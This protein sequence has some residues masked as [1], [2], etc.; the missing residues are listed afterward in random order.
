MLSVNLDEKKLNSGNLTDVFKIALPLILVASSNSIKLFSDRSMLSHYS[1]AQMEAA[2][3]SGIT[4]FTML[5]FFI[6]VVSYCN[7]FVS[8]FYG[9]KK[10]SEIGK[11]IWQGIFIS[12]FAGIILGTGYFWSDYLFSFLGRD[13][14]MHRNQVAYVKVLYISSFFPLCMATLTNFWGG[15]GKTWLVLLIE[16]T[17][18]ILNVILN[19]CL[20]FG[21]FGFPECGLLGAAYAT[22]ASTVVGVVVAFIIFLSKSNREQFNTLP[23]KFFDFQLA[24]KIFIYGSQNGIR[25]VLDVGAFNV[26]VILL[27]FYGPLVGEAS[28]IVFTVN[29]LS[30]IP[31]FGI[32]NSVSI[33]VGHGIGSKD[34]EMSKR[35]VGSG[36]KILLIYMSIV[37]S[38][39]TLCNDIPLSLF[40][41]DSK[42]LYDMTKLF[43]YFVACELFFN[44]FSILYSSAISGAG[45]TAFPM[46]ITLYVSWGVFVLPLL[47][48]Y[49]SGVSYMIA[50]GIFAFHVFPKAVILYLRYRDGVWQKMSVI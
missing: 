28:T 13:A 33:L 44:G 7:V 39:L 38:L 22:A 27:S 36:L 5:I 6:A 16:G 17:T 2:F 10:Y 48:I 19:Y 3:T 40:S 21:R 45:D 1:N 42:E 49:F 34:I 37:L 46:K 8:Q 12:L 35:V 41:F 20:I 43:M 15:L 4:Y 14:E 23:D 26:F 11:V 31:L 9:A 30:F 47:I 25:A 18:V 50:W 24:K 29:A 32:G